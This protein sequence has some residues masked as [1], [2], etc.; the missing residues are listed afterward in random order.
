MKSNAASFGDLE[1]CDLEYR[2][3]ADNARLIL[4]TL[5]QFEGIP[6]VHVAELSYEDRLDNVMLAMKDNIRYQTRH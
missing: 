2:F 3:G 1:F 5:E 4:R 6:E